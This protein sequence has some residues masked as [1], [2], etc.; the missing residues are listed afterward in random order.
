MSTTC[1]SDGDLHHLPINP[2]VN[3]S[4]SEAYELDNHT[5]DKNS[6]YVSTSLLTPL[7]ENR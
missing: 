2:A 6:E 3:T 4:S 1:L 5:T 7:Q